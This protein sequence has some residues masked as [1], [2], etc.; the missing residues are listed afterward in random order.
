MTFHH[1]LVRLFCMVSLVILAAGIWL[2]AD[3][4]ARAGSG[5][6]APGELL[7]WGGGLLAW[8]FLGGLAA[9]FA[10]GRG[11]D[12]HGA[13]APGPGRLI[14][15]GGGRRLWV[16][17]WGDEHA[18][19]IV[20]TH[21][22][23]LDGSVWREARRSLPRR[24]RVIA[25]DLAGHGRSPA[26]KDGDMG[27]ERLALDLE[28]VLQL[29]HG[30]AILAGHGHGALVVQ[31]LLRARPEATLPKVAGVVL[32]N[33]AAAA[34]AGASFLGPLL[35]A[36]ERPVLRPLLKLEMALSPLVRLMW[37]QAALS[38]WMQAA[39]RISGFG[40]RPCRPLLA[41][42]SRLQARAAPRTQGAAIL[43]AM[44][45][46]RDGANRQAL[47]GLRLE[48][49]VFCG[50]R[51]LAVRPQASAELASLLHAEENR[52]GFAGHFGPIECP[53]WYDHAL[54][55]F[56]DKVFTQGAV[57][58]DR[59]AAA[60]DAPAP[61]PRPSPEGRSWARPT[62]VRPGLQRM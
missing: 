31:A 29:A 7:A 1:L 51:D 19:A 28:A 16:E 27:L 56:A 17:S 14:E 55:A 9:R 33:G 23:G 6:A 5:A 25:W 54:T 40:G 48:A 50:G 8:S 18:P 46:D 61:A 24:Y 2:V 42:A 49:L 12:L 26:P 57:W 58:A 15:A 45:F 44:D 52:A 41:H 53:S 32:Q 4:A 13:Y 38:G 59:A 60:R 37:R 22:L 20:L 36:L 11:G 3:W 21:D 62:G 34:P 43:A 35:E 10:L 47:A 30:P 39:Q